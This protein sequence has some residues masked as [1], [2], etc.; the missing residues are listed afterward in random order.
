[1]TRIDL[2][3]S[4]PDGYRRV[5]QFDTYVDGALDAQ[6]KNLVYLR[7]SQLNGCT[8]CVDRHSSDLIA[9]GFPIRKVLA[10]SAWR[11]CDFF[12]P[13]EVLVLELTESITLI[14][15]PEGQKTGVPD[16]LWSRASE[17][18]TETELGDLLL[19]ISMIN[20]WNRIGVTEL[21]HPEPLSAED[22]TTA[23]AH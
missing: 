2:S 14:S 22:F 7:A 9:A 20:V 10:V 19:G 17:S 18:F 16:E 15:S 21:L 11:H 4:N 12:S 8:Y 3:K 23:A 1:M 5:L 13:R 6:T